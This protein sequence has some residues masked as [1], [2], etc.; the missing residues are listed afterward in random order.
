MKNQG[1]FRRFLNSVVFFWSKLFMVIVCHFEIIRADFHRVLVLQNRDLGKKNGLN[2]PPPWNVLVLQ[3]RGLSKKNCAHVQ[4]HA[5][6]HLEMFCMSDANK[7]VRV[8]SRVWESPRTVAWMSQKLIW[9]KLF[10]NWGNVAIKINM[11]I[12]YD[13]FQE[14]VPSKAAK[15]WFL[16]FLWI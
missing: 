2:G 6:L 10:W 13:N 3:N 5:D 15:A 12:F 1:N 16:K 4:N 7:N 14:I 11:Q 9:F 8:R